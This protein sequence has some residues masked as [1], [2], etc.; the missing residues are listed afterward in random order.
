MR[1]NR[2][3]FLVFLVLV[4][5]AGCSSKDDKDFTR[6]DYNK[7]GKLIFEELIV[8][9]PDLTVEEFLAADAD[10]NGFIDDK[11]YERF[12]EARRAGKKL[13]TKPG[14]TPETPA[15]KPEV[16]APDGTAPA[17]GTTTA[18]TP[19][20]PDAATAP[21]AQTPATPTPIPA[22]QTP[23][24]ISAAPVPP[25]AGAPAP[26]PELTAVPESA[27]VASV[28]AP[29]E[30]VEIVSPSLAPEPAATPAPTKT[31]VVVR[32][33][34]LS[35]IAKRFGVTLKALM[36]A[37]GLKNADR[38]EAG[39][40]LT[41]PAPDAAT[42]T[43]VSGGTPAPA[44]VTAFVADFFVKSASGNVN[45]LVDD[46]ADSVNYYRKGKSGRDIVRQDKV[47]YFERWPKRT[48]APGAATVASV[49]GSEDLQVTVPVA[50]TAARGDKTTSGQ[51]V[52][53]FRLRPE[54]QTYRIVGEQSVAGKRSVT[55]R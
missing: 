41:I 52:F 33:D 23:A 49:A 36:D 34:N 8:V 30:S 38:V 50:Y 26:T 22:T 13:E 48:Y 14:V 12:R 6:V 15:A 16:P 29:G 4:A 1:L 43:P 32:G 28:P 11:E 54:G 9:F 19:P 18:P 21:A 51:A 45:A 25:P 46:Y 10:H 31:Y 40:S 27:P 35:R 44:A 55:H 24:P 47:A 53:T 2:F 39:A 42:G 5:L 20:A 7:D 17:G 3:A 37:N